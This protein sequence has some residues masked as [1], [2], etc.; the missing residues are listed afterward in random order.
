L[1]SFSHSNTGFISA[2]D[3]LSYYW[4]HQSFQCEQGQCAQVDNERTVKTDPGQR[5]KQ[6]GDRIREWMHRREQKFN[7]VYV[8]DKEC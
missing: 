8:D 4:L 7:L 2:A 3:G 1:P 5:M 6:Y